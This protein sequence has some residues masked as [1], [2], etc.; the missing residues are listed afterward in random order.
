MNGLKSDRSVQKDW[1]RAP[2]FATNLEENAWAIIRFTPGQR[3]L[4]EAPN[5]GTASARWKGT[6]TEPRRTPGR[7]LPTQGA[8]TKRTTTHNHGGLIPNEGALGSSHMRNQQHASKRVIDNL[9]KITR[10]NPSENA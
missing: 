6:P 2:D 4:P 8:T 10:L 3:I 9:T 1:P 5:R 7:R